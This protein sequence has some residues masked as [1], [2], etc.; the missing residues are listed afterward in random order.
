MQIGRI[1]AASFLALFSFLVSAVALASATPSN[2]NKV[3]FSRNGVDESS[4]SASYPELA[5]DNIVPVGDDF[6]ADGEYCYST[7]SGK[8]GETKYYL[9]A[10]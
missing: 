8:T 1:M 3:S 7:Y 9:K 5:P 4:L 6:V 2:T 10:P